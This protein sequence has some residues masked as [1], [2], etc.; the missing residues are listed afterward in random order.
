[1]QNSQKNMLKIAI[2]SE[3]YQKT[4]LYYQHYL[5]LEVTIHRIHVSNKWIVE[6]K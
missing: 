2:F 1:M 5:I 6:P 4:K 3:S